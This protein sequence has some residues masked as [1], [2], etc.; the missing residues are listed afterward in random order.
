M[1]ERGALHAVAGLS[2]VGLGLGLG[3]KGVATGLPRP[4]HAKP[5]HQ[6]WL[7]RTYSTATLDPRYH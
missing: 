1:D 6:R 2:G 3:K 5:P 4:V 7:V